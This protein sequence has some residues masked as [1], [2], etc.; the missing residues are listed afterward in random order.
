MLG[1]DKD[2]YVVQKTVTQ[3]E[4]LCTVK[5]RTE[6][7]DKLK[8]AQAEVPDVNARKVTGCWT[9]GLNRNRQGAKNS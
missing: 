3:R 1:S 4:L 2:I 6:I 8:A 9:E 7:T 5:G